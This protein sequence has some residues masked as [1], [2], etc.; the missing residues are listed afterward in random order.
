[1][2]IPEG[3]LTFD[4][5]GLL[6][7]FDEDPVPIPGAGVVGWDELMNAVDDEEVNGGATNRS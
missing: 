5:L 6:V 2:L 3:V 4:T 7:A 1:M